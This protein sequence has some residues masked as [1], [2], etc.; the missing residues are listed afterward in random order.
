MGYNYQRVQRK[1]FTKAYLIIQV[2]LTS[3]SFF[4]RLQKLLY[5]MYKNCIPGWIGQRFPL[6][7]EKAQQ[8][9]KLQIKTEQR[10]TI[11]GICRTQF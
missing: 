2:P 7:A 1:A 3:Y 10:L 11:H 4:S 9:G 6:Y 5:K 8:N